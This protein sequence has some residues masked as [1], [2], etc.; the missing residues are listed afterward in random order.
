MLKPVCVKC[1]ILSYFHKFCCPFNIYLALD[2]ALG[3]L[4]H[5]LFLGSI[6][7]LFFP[8]LMPP[9]KYFYHHLWLKLSVCCLSCKSHWYWFLYHKYLVNGIH[10]EAFPDVFDFLVTSAIPHRGLFFT[11]YKHFLLYIKIFCFL[12]S[13]SQLSQLVEW[14]LTMSL[15]G[16]LLSSVKLLCGPTS[17]TGETVVSEWSQIVP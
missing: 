2:P 15:F 5:N 14:S 17:H 16:C 6:L 13:L 8:T 3:Q 10:Y 4:N 7:I 1:V 12:C 11:A 9:K